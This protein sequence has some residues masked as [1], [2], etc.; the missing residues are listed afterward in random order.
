M[1]PK[2]TF[3]D[4]GPEYREITDLEFFMQNPQKQAQVFRGFTKPFSFNLTSFAWK[5]G[6]ARP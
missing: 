5:T 6:Q 1:M 4:L 2:K 3:P